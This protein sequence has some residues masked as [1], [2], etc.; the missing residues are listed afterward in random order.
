MRIFDSGVS[1]LADALRTT[2]STPC[3]PV[4]VRLPLSLVT[5]GVQV[6]PARE[7]SLIK[8]VIELNG[9]RED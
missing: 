5:G 2:A 7:I 1:L 8:I 6:G 3:H 9:R 4:P